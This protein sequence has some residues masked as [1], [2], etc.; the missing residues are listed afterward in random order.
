MPRLSILALLLL[1]CTWWWPAPAAAQVRQCIGSDGAL[2]YTD[3]KCE[4]IGG[5]DRPP[6]AVAAIGNARSARGSCARSVQDLAY[7]LGSAI[8]SGDANQIASVYD[9]AGM[10]TENGYRLFARLEAIAKRPLVEVQ[11]MY[12]GGVNEY[13][14][15]IVQFD[16]DSGAVLSQP[17]RKPR[18]VGLRVEQTLGNGSTPSRTV[19]GLRQ[20]LGCWWVRL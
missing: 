4:D 9:W 10:S 2:V 8:Q 14:D 13:G 15:G 3:R 11:P 5:R 7:S 1:A 12:A 19:F 16:A 17:T 20:H 18:L 6:S